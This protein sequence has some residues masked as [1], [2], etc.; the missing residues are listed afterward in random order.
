MH[1]ESPEGILLKCRFWLIMGWGLKLYISNELPSDAD[2]ACSVG[3]TEHLGGGLVTQWCL[4][5]CSP[6][7]VAC[8][9]SLSM[10]F[11]WLE[12]WSGLPFHSL[13]NLPY[14]GIELRS[15]ALQED[16]LL[17]ESLGKPVEQLKFSFYRRCSQ[18]ALPRSLRVYVDASGTN[19]EGWMD[20]QRHENSR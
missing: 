3:Q 15:P 19:S 5:L 12:Y 10:E 20:N 16:S 11:S 17:T 18:P 4:T 2:A 9:A 13:W 1:F 14:P 8:Q 6:W 7:T